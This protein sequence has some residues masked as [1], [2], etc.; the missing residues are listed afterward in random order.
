MPVVGY[1]GLETPDLY[2][3][4]LRAFRARASARSV[5]RKVAT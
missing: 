3:T 2:A 1:L 5:I 4:R